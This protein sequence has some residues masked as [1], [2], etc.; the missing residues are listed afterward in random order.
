MNHKI[1]FIAGAGSLALS[2]CT[3]SADPSQ[4][5]LF[6]SPSK[7]QDQIINPLKAQ[8]A[9]SQARLDA[10]QSRHQ[11]LLKKQASLNAQLRKARQN[12]SSQATIKSL[13]SEVASLQR[14]MDA[15]SGVSD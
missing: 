4:G 13:E 7:C 10:A 15:L 1:L 2:S 11:A 12:G 14:Q 8:E 5:G 3:L 6:W 9:A